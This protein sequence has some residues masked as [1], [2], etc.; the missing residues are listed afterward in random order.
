MNYGIWNG[1]TKRFVFGINEPTKARALRKFIKAAGKASYCWRYE[2]RK[3][4]DNY[5]NPPNPLYKKR[6]KNNEV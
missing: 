5:K 6:V 2:V 1:M 3:R 4:P